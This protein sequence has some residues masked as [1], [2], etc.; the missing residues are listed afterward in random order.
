[1]E[2]ASRLSVKPTLYIANRGEIALRIL[3]TAKKMGFR[4]CVGFATQDEDLPFVK[5]ADTSVNLEGEEASQTYLNTEKVLAAAKSLGSTHLHPGYGFL[6]ENAGFVDLVTQAGIKFVGPSAESMRLLGDKI[7]SR[8]FL[9]KMGIPLLPSYE[10]D[11]QSESTLLAEAKKLGF[12]LLIK[13][14]AG[15]GG[16]GMLRVDR[17]EDVI[18]KLQSSKRIAKSAFGDDRVFLERLIEKARHIEVQILAD[19]HGHVYTV[20]ERECSLQKRHQKVVEE[21]PAQFISEKIR[22]KLWTHS[23]RIAEEAKYTSLG[24]VEWIWDRQDG[25]YF[26]EVNARLQVEHPVTEAVWRI[27][28]VEQQLWAALG[29]KLRALDLQPRGHAIEVRI[30]AEDPA[31]EFLPTGGKIHRLKLPQNVRA[32]FGFR[33]KNVIPSQFDSLIGKLIAFGNDR[34]EARLKLIEALELLCIF[35]PVTNR[36]YLL[37]LLKHPSVIAGEI[38]TSLLSEIP[39]Q[40]DLMFGVELLRKLGRKPTV[41]ATALRDST[42]D[43]LDFYSPWGAVP[44]PHREDEKF[45]FEDIAGRRFFHADWGDWSERLNRDQVANR[46]ST[47]NASLE[48]RSPMPGRIIRLTKKVGDVVKAG[49]VILVLEAMKMEHQIKAPR[50]ARVAKILAVE[51]DRVAMDAELVKFEEVK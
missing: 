16:K 42:D 23:R 2:K 51:G 5:E 50:E 46:D 24:T 33:E 1:L 45:Y 10:G 49:E 19:E 29:E 14:S 48:I 47:T 20:G 36:S 4:T 37:Q 18:E 44:Q 43:D 13:P 38:S 40:F 32:D 15:G 35:G 41:D 12:P 7:G 8:K 25:I 6:S 27:D 9:K 30:C 31:R 22:Q 39:Y 28:L 17:A 21:A 3:R 34:E 11:D 26:L